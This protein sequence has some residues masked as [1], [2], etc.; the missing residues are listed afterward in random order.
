MRLRFSTSHILVIL[1]LTAFCGVAAA[2]QTFR[3]ELS[4]D[5]VYRISHEAMMTAGLKQPI[6]YASLSL[7]SMGENVPIW[8]DDTDEVFGPGDTLSFIGH[9]ARGENRFF[10]EYADTGVY[11]LTVD[12]DADQANVTN[13]TLNQMSDDITTSCCVHL[14]QNHHAE[15]DILYAPLTKA[16]GDESEFWYWGKLSS[17]NPNPFVHEF[18]TVDLSDEHDDTRAVLTLAFL[19]WSDPNRV[20]SN[21]PDHVVDIRLNDVH[22]GQAQWNDKQRHVIEI[23]V[24]DDVLTSNGSNRLSLNVV[25]RPSDSSDENSPPVIDIVYLDW[26]EIETFRHGRLD[27]EEPQVR[28]MPVQSSSASDISIISDV[29]RIDYFPVDG[30]RSIMS[31][32]ATPQLQAASRHVLSPENPSSAFW[33]VQDAAFLEPD[34]IGL[35]TSSDVLADLHQVDYLMI[36]HPSLQD[37]IKPLAEFHRNNGLSVRIVNVDSLYDQFNHGH[38]HPN[39]I[40]TF[41]KHVYAMQEQPV[42]RWVLL[43]GDASWFS[44]PGMDSDQFVQRNLIPSWQFLTQHGPAASDAAFAELDSVEGPDVAVGR[45]PVVSVTELE[46]IV[47]KTIRYLRENTVGPWRSRAYTI[48]D[49]VAEHITRNAR[50]SSTVEDSGFH[51][52]GIGSDSRNHDARLGDIRQAFDDGQLIV[53]FYGHGGRYMWQTGAGNIVDSAGFFDLEQIDM[54]QANTRLPL[55]LSMTCNTGPFDHPNA[56][57]LAEKF[58]RLPDRGA[59]AVLSASARNS[60]ARRFSEA[61]FSASFGSQTIG[62]TIRQVKQTHGNPTM[63]ALYNLMGDPALRLAVPEHSL[64]IERI[65][66]ESIQVYRPLRR[67]K[68]EMTVT[69]LD[70]DNQLLS[71]ERLK[72]RKKKNRIRIPESDSGTITRVKI[73]AWDEGRQT[74]AI[75][76]ISL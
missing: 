10:H 63:N 19:G 51:V 18:E 14:Q 29:S 31:R 20:S 8:R 39:A 43:A 22:I 2:A 58:L 47:D 46:G 49:Q 36:T 73:Y 7:S 3:I 50:L 53:S 25:Q 67:F 12:S 15:R 30:G 62:E 21:D 70:D 4:Q 75:G 35:S 40:S 9:Q 52:D 69:W 76:E 33:L 28:L 26:M 66:G 64:Q 37:A 68:G 57:S 27:R 24:P 55:I 71:T 54:L 45:F 34:S 65:S 16:F 60:P 32:S 1:T 17:A 38:V 61:L 74:D 59:I 44:K 48:N 72:F 41:L 5:G 23:E 42:L 56:D 13:T 11:W 6:H